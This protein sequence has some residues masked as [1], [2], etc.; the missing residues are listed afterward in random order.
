MQL[1]TGLWEED[2]GVSLFT[3]SGIPLV[4]DGFLFGRLALLP[5]TS[6]RHNEWVRVVGL[7]RDDGGGE[8][9]RA[10]GGFPL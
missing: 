3:G 6:L 10:P 8:G 7:P 2:G 1:L 5:F 9:A 4:L